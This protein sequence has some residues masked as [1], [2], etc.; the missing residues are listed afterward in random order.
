MIRPMRKDD[1]SKVYELWLS[2]KGMGLNDVDDSENGISRFLNHNPST[3]F[4]AEIKG[5]LIGAIMAGNDG[6]RGYILS[7]GST[8][9]SSKQGNRFIFGER[10]AGGSETTGNQQDGISCI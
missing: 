8:S 10:R 2:C 1:Y 3:C 7:Y 9:L 5:E 6:R 4:V